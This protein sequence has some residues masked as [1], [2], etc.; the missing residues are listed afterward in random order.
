MTGLGTSILLGVAGA[1]VSCTW[2]VFRMPEDLC[3]HS[4]LRLDLLIMNIMARLVECLVK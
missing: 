3:V 4:L 2:I 1:V